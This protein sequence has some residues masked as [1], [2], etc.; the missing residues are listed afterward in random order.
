MVLLLFL[1]FF[2]TTPLC[3]LNHKLRNDDILDPA[4]IWAQYEHAAAAAS[5]ANSS[6]DGGNSFYDEL[7]N[8]GLTV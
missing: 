6:N 4:S 2:L 8:E 5:A 1:P 3:A 7:I